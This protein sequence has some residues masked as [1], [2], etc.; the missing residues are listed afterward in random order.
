MFVPFWLIFLATG[1]IMA[2]FAVVWGIRTS[3]FDNQERARF[4]PLFGL[5]ERPAEN[6]GTHRA[7]YAAMVILVS[8]GMSALGAGLFLALRHM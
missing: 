2:V 8:V 5:N 4:I 6:P 7:D 3:Q 1:L